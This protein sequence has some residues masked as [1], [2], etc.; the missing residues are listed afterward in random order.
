MGSLATFLIFEFRVDEYVRVSERA[1]VGEILDEV[2]LCEGSCQ[3][4]LITPRGGKLTSLYQS[5]HSFLE[6]TTPKTSA[7]EKPSI[8]SSPLKTGE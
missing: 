1:G 8:S 7:G 2:A 4:R 5:S 3:Q 6:P